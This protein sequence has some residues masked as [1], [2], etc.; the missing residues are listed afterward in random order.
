MDRISEEEFIRL[1]GLSQGRIYSFIITL[2]PDWT[3]AEEVLARTSVVLWKK[4]AEFDSSGDFV[5]WACGI[6]YRQTMAYLREQ[7]RGHLTLSM[8]VLEQIAQQRLD[9][10]EL[11]EER[12]RALRGCLE[13]LP[14]SDRQII[15]TYYDCTKKTAAEVGSQLG[16]PANTILKA[17]VRIRRALHG[18]I[19]RTI[20]RSESS[21]SGETA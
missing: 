9:Q 18:C 13:K 10:D 12:R 19:D 21:A 2:L 16:R 8:D 14:V 20:A 1:L 15:E 3:E 11:L 7:R 17:L 5:R 4:I 6:A